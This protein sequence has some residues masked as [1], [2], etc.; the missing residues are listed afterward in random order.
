VIPLPPISLSAPSSAK[1]E[2][3]QSLGDFRFGDNNI[4][5][6]AGGLSPWMIGGVVV[7]VV[8]GIIL[9]LR[10]KN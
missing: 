2:A 7:V 10:R 8:I 3:S 5:A 4:G 1:G 6:G 9:W